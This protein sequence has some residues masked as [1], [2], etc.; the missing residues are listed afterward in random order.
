MNFGPVANQ[1]NTPDIRAQQG[2]NGPEQ[3]HKSDIKT[4]FEKL[5]TFFK[6]TVLGRFG[7]KADYH[8]GLGRLFKIGLSRTD[9][10]IPVAP[11]SAQ[12]VHTHTFQKLTKEKAK[13]MMS[14]VKAAM[15]AN[16]QGVDELKKGDFN[17]GRLLYPNAKELKLNKRL[18]MV[19][20]L[21]QRNFAKLTAGEKKLFQD[22][23]SLCS[24]KAYI[25]PSGVIVDPASGLRA[26]VTK[27]PAQPEKYIIS[28]GSTGSAESSDD[29]ALLCLKQNNANIR[30]Y[31]GFVPTVYEQAKQLTSAVVNLC[32]KE[33]VSTTGHSLGGGLAQFAALHNGVKGLCLNGSPLGVGLQKNLGDKLSNAGQLISH[34]SMRGDWLSYSAAALPISIFIPKNEFSQTS[35]PDTRPRTMSKIADFLGIRTRGNF[36]QKYYFNFNKEVAKASIM[37]A[38]DENL[39]NKD[40]FERYKAEDKLKKF[41]EIETYRELSPS[42]ETEKKTAKDRL[43]RPAFIKVDWDSEKAQTAVLEKAERQSKDTSVMHCSILAQL[44]SLA[45]D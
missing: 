31:L 21:N 32:G 42:E 44:S 43:D 39:A 15:L 9:S 35:G 19:G 14:S 4:F 17:F 28:F 24:D 7:A 33:N 11:K 12:P 16:A 8:S 27:D 6:E 22:I 20:K 1:I 41:K 45:A 2:T 26:A 10:K 23:K 29:G 13:T 36:G 25:S 37:K 38:T 5:G 18:D 34:V 40:E 30:Q 3:T